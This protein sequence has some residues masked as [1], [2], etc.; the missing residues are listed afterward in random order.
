MTEQPSEWRFKKLEEIADVVRGV[1]YS[2]K[3]VVTSGTSD[4][5]MLLRATNIQDG[6]LDDLD[7]VYIPRALVKNHQFLI[8]GDIIMASSSGSIQIVGKNALVRENLDA[9]FGAFCT[10][11]RARDVNPTFLFYFLQSPVLRQQWSD[12]ARGSNINN[13]KTTDTASTIVPVPPIEEQ[14]QIVEQ[15]DVQ[16]YKLEKSRESLLKL[17]LLLKSLSRSL[18]HHNVSGHGDLYSLS[19]LCTL[20]TDGSHF[21]PKTV[22]RGFPYI[23]VRDL[24]DS[25]IDFEN[26]KYINEDSFLELERSGCSP[27]PGDVLFSKDGTVGKVALVSSTEPFVVLS[28]LAILRPNS[29]LITPEFL[30]LSLRSPEV[31]EQALGM[32]SGTAIR[33]VVLRTLKTLEIAVPSLDKQRSIVKFVDAELSKLGSLDNQIEELIAQH[34]NLRRSLLHAAFAGQ[35]TKEN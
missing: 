13:L 15:L 19:E 22:E 11:I 8:P 34:E 26:C 5:I 23:T 27:K 33:R 10:V 4:S 28:S 12:L 18:L 20:I 30:K 31:L 9:T 2:A 29:S 25:G 14:K 32:K 7:P 6:K 21:S 35:L 17:K 3:D 16:L 1:T 24:Q